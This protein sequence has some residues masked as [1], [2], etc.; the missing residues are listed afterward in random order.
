MLWL[1]RGR[2]SPPPPQ[3]LPSSYQPSFSRGWTTWVIS[4]VWIISLCQVFLAVISFQFNLWIGSFIFR[5]VV[6]ELYPNRINAGPY[7][8]WHHCSFVMLLFPELEGGGL[9]VPYS[10]TGTVG[11]CSKKDIHPLLPWS[12]SPFLQ[13]QH[14]TTPGPPPA[15]PTALWVWDPP[16]SCSHGSPW[17]ALGL[18]HQEQGSWKVNGWGWSPVPSCASFFRRWDC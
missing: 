4:A 6:A 17:A 14:W 3:Y 2:D 10:S 8:P 1:F 7:L 9:S 12:A 5:V 13:D 11:M 18:P 15:R 16:G